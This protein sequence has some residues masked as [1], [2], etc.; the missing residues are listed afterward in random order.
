MNPYSYP[1]EYFLNPNFYPSPYYDY[2][3]EDFMANEFYGGGYHY[4][5]HGGPEGTL[6]PYSNFQFKPLP[7][8]ERRNFLDLPKNKFARDFYIEDQSNFMAT[9]HKRS[10]EPILEPPKIFM[11]KQDQ[12][13]ENIEASNQNA[14]NLATTSSNTFANSIDKESSHTMIHKRNQ[15]Q[16]SD[17]KRS[18]QFHDIENIAAANSNN[19]EIS[20]TNSNNL[21]SSKDK[22][23]SNM[24][25]HKRDQSQPS[26]QKRSIVDKKPSVFVSN[27]NQD[28]ENIEAESF[29]ENG[30]SAT[31]INT[32]ASAKDKE[33]SKTSF[34]KRIL[35]NSMPSFSSDQL[36]DIQN[37]EVANFKSAQMSATN[38]NNFA[39]SKDKGASNTIMIS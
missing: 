26:D 4:L 28:I 2:S 23:S 5:F 33:S 30:I 20:T 18:D 12:D 13:I 22:E 16:S 1:P 27:Q 11:S 8:Y 25:I 7:L 38:A 32:F 21:V 34:R 6:Y 36:Q 37:L 35:L 19:V 3:P 24:V 39:S 29:N 31:E 14:I 9:K 17:H 10:A 15:P